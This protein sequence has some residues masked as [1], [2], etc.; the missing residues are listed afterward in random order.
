MTTSFEAD[1][2][3]LTIDASQAGE[4]L[5]RVLAAAWPDLS[6]SRLKQLIEAGR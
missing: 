1:R 6:R 2:R 3:T 5:D 4:R